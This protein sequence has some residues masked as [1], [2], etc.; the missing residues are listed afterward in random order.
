MIRPR[1]IPV[2]LLRDGG[3]VKGQKFKDHKYVGDPTNAV[4][5]FNEKEVDELIFL[6][7]GASNNI[8]KGPNFGLIADIAGEA[9]FPLGYGGGLENVAQIEKL[10]S[11]GIEKAII[12]S[13]AFNNPALV[14]EGAKLAG[15]SSIVVS[16]DVK[17]SIFNKYE[18]FINNGQTRTKTDP[19][20]F[21][22]RMEDLG[23]GE[24][25]LSSINR[26]GTGEGYDLELISAVS[27]SV[28]IPV[29]CLGGAGS[30]RDLNQA[31][32]SSSISGVAA[33]DLFVF[34]G[35]HKAVLISYISH[36]ELSSFTAG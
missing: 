18:V 1:I 9:F 28:D 2:L 30:A 19:I 25:I 27:D 20:T 31:L 33:G 26:E 14:K 23:A 16:I 11:L 3:L 34:H 32:E 35:K 36:D 24:I 22:K 13:A 12:N 10:F 8:P 6:D 4:R 7:I 29:V 15:S 5:I 17:R 21:A